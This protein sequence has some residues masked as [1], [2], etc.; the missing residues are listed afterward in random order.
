ML[1]RSREIASLQ[2][3]IY[4]VFYVVYDAMRDFDSLVGMESREQVKDCMCLITSSRSLQ[5][6][7]ENVD[8]ELT[9]VNSCGGEMY[10]CK[11]LIYYF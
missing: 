6:K 5:L 10:C 11:K 2:G 1:E 8:I 3:A 9:L 4:N 7:G